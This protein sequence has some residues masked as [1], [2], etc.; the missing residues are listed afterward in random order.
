MLISVFDLFSIGLGPSSSHTIGPMR[1]A[2]CFVQTLKEREELDRVEHVKVELFGSLAYTGKGHRTDV[3]LILGLEGHFSDQVT[4]EEVLALE[5]K[6]QKTSRLNL[7]QEKEIDFDFDNDITLLKSKRLPLH[8]NAMRFTAKS[9]GAKKVFSEVYYSVGG[10]FILD[11]KAMAVEMEKEAEIDMEMQP[12]HQQ[13]PSV[14]YPFFTA[15]QL[16]EHCESHQLSIGDLMMENEKHYRSE[17]EVKEGLARLQQVMKESIQRGLNTDGILPGGLNVK[18]RAKGLHDFLSQNTNRKKSP[19]EAMDWVS[20]FAI[21]VNE[22]NAAGGRVVTAP[23]NGASGV[24]PAVMMYIDRFIE[25]KEENW[26]EEFLLTSGAIGLLYKEGAS[27][28]AAE[29]GCQG[30]VGV[31][32]SMAAAGLAAVMGAT[33]RQ[34]ENAAE[35]AME[36]HLGLTCDPIAGLV[37]I[38]CIERNS[39]GA[40][41]AINS[42]QL[43]L[44]GDGEH[45]VSLDKV[46]KTMLQTGKDMHSIYKETSEGGLAVNVIEC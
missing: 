11:H 30:E 40:I 36:H 44:R 39:M 42:A 25:D 13:K 41:K 24:I 6:V 5:E 31:A 2:L 27:L 4:T 28:S 18:R 10:G 8:S 45:I 12:D 7:L 33:V 15:K 29:V 21:A 22:E 23:T 19:L 43:A 20:A 3:A 32:S 37:Q 16:L 46:I 1:A 35:I 26:L 14:A 34:A 9:A 38:P 17:K